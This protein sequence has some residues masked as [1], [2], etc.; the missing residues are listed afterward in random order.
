[1]RMIKLTRRVLAVFMPVLLC[2]SA[3][4]AADAAP[5]DLTVMTQNL[6]VGADADVVLSNPTPDTIAAAF[7]SVVANNFP[8][9]AAALLRRRPA[10]AGRC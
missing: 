10:P 2:L 3:G 4:R 9:R 5:V 7:Q 8:A 6:Y 1:M